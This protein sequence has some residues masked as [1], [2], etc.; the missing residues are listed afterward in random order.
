MTNTQDSNND[1]EK[2]II[3]LFDRATKPNFWKSITE[4]SQSTN[5][6][7]EDVLQVV[8]NSTA[9]VQSKSNKKEVV[10]T[11]KEC[12]RKYQSFGRKLLGAFRNRID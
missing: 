2:L 7:I 4:I 9:F 1:A 6:P 11:T 12:F 3:D 5:L 10:Y 8:S